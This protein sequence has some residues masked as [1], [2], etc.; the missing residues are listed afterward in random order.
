MLE[1]ELVD[2]DAEF[3]REVEEAFEART[4]ISNFQDNYKLSF[5]GPLIR[6]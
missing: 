2:P 6:E 3:G 5:S 4:V 1:M